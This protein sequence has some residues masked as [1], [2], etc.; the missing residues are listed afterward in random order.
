MI[1]LA[2]YVPKGDKKN[3]DFFEEYLPRVYERRAD[4]GLPDIVGDMSGVVIQV[5]HGDARQLPG[6]A[7]GDGPL[8]PAG[9][10]RLTDDPQGLPAPL[11][12]RV[13][14]ADRARAAEPPA[15]RTRSR[16][17]TCCTRWLEPQ[18]ER[19]LHRGDLPG[20]SRSV[21]CARRS[22]RRTSGSST[23]ATP[24]NAFYAREH[25]TFTFLSRLHLQP[26]RLRRRRPRRPRRARSRRA[27]QRCRPRS[28]ASST[29]RTRCRRSTGS[30]T[31]CSGSTTWP[32]GSWPA[33]ARTRSSSTSRWSRTTSGAPTTS[34]R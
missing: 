23:R 2:T 8:P 20:V 14:P 18:A 32:P 17:G 27:C 1:D 9:D 34:R 21:P 10:V 25:L 11:A 26:G 4:S 7:R 30:R 29:G 3:S 24:P 13:P 12:A 5:D 15:T 19:A 33:T 28:R 31:W 22:S 16:A 6:R